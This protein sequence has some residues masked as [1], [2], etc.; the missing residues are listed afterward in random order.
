[1]ISFETWWF[2]A[3]LPLPWLAY[4]LLP[5]AG[6]HGA[7]L[8]APFAQQLATLGNTLRRQPGSKPFTLLLLAAAWL[9]LLTSLNRPVYLGEPVQVPTEARDLMLAVDIS[10]SM[11]RRDMVV[12]DRRAMRIES[13]KHV[14]QQ[15]IDRRTGDRLGLLLFADQAYQQAPLTYD[16]NTVK[17]LLLDAQLGFAGQQTAIGDAI[18]LAIKRLV[19]RPAKSRTLILLTDGANNTGNVAPVEAAELAAQEGVKIYTIGI[20]ADKIVERSVFGNR[21][22]NPSRDLDERSLKEIARLTGGEYFRARN[23]EQLEGIYEKFDALE[24]VDQEALT[25]RPRQQLF[26]VPLGIALALYALA[27][28]TNRTGFSYFRR[29]MT[30]GGSD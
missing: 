16:R 22:R 12:N 4:R 24:P 3:F 1:M 5:P 15:F 9:A 13:V 28:L 18:G 10:G 7:A 29:P 27:L 19:E 26:Y 23:T 25:F 2:F 20:G 14:L 6:D 21:T 17:Q 11:D 8:R 30:A